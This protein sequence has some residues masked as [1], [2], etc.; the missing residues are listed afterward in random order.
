MEGSRAF[1]QTVGG[2]G[3]VLSATVDTMDRLAR[4]NARGVP[5]LRAMGTALVRKGRRGPVFVHVAVR[6]PAHSATRP[7][8][9][10]I[11][12]SVTAV[13]SAGAG[14]A[15]LTTTTRRVVRLVVAPP[16]SRAL[17]NGVKSQTAEILGTPLADGHLEV[18]VLP[19]PI[20]L[21]RRATFS[22]KSGDYSRVAIF[23]P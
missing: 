22:L 13:T 21:M 6:T 11:K 3:R 8:P 20:L 19:V 12:A 7:I 4:L 2:G 1:A 18:L 9:A 10:S 14:G 15:F 16:S 23:G 17:P 5:L